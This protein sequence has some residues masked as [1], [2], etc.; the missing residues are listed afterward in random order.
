MLSID[1]AKFLDTSVENNARIC[2]T[3]N[4]VRSAPLVIPGR[5]LHCGTPV[6]QG[7]QGLIAM[8]MEQDQ[9][10]LL[11]RKLHFQRAIFKIFRAL[12]RARK[13]RGE[14]GSL[15]GGAVFEVSQKQS[16]SRPCSEILDGH[17]LWPLF[18]GRSGSLFAVFGAVFGAN[19]MMLKTEP[20]YSGR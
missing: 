9:R 13:K 5:A 19:I 17:K 4:A 2:Q 8:S 14:K 7:V 1:P 20:S 11:A 3:T 18:R 15:R 10:A 16:R 6:T 12:P